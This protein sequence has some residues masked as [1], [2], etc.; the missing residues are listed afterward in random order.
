MTLNSRAI[1]SSHYLPLTKYFEGAEQ[2]RTA[3]NITWSSTNFKTILEWQ[4]KPTNYVYT[5]EISGKTTNWKKSPFCMWTEETECD[6][7]SL[8]EDVHETYSARIIS[9][10]R[11]NGEREEFPYT[12]TDKFTPYKQ[13]NIGMPKFNVTAD[14]S[15]GLLKVMIEDP[16]SH[17]RFANGSLKSIREFF[18]DDLKYYVYYWKAKSTGKKTDSTK[19]NVLE[20]AV[21]KDES[22]CVYVQAFIPSRRSNRY[23]Q[24]STIRCTPGGGGFGEYGIGFILAMIFIAVLILAIIIVLS[25]WLWKHKRKAERKKKEKNLMPLQSA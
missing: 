1:F 2:L 11:P 22:Y 25:V 16:V 7:T 4:P 6:L 8:M 23:G 15:K 12:L 21:D 10:Q 14:Q 17:Y 19:D 20:I 5:V 3:H 24:Q 18:K 13:T 9:E